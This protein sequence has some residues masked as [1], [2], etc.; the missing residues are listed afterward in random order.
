MQICGYLRAQRE[1]E[2]G[3]M[4]NFQTWHGDRPDPAF[5]QRLFTRMTL[6]SL[7]CLAVSSIALA[8]PPVVTTSASAPQTRE[9]AQSIQ[10]YRFFWE[11]QPEIE[12]KLVRERKIPVQAVSKDVDSQVEFAM[13]AG[14]MVSAPLRFTFETARQ[15]DQLKEVSGH[16]KKVQYNAQDQKLFL[17]LEALGYQARM[18]LQIQSVEAPQRAQIQW[19]VIAGHFKGMTGII[20]FKDHEFQKTRMALRARYKAKVLPLPKVLMGFAL[21]VITQK[22]AEKMRVYIEGAYQAELKKQQKSKRKS[23]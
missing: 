6:V 11:D 21:E 2:V 3:D 9:S 23:P 22:V 4:E 12:N 14:G 1:T 19:E 10:E 16:F 18:L 7:T 15:Y 20:D 5:S 13:A 17:H 8:G